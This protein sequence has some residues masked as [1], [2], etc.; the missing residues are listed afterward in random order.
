M[1]RGITSTLVVP[2]QI[3]LLALAL[4]ACGAT[5][6]QVDPGG[7]AGSGQRGSSEFLLPDGSAGVITVDG[8]SVGSDAV[9]GSAN[10]SMSQKPADVLLLLDRSGSMACSMTDPALDCKPT[11]GRTS[12]RWTVLSDGLR[13]VLDDSITGIHWGLKLFA[14]PS[15]DECGVTAGADVAVGAGRGPTIE[16]RMATTSQ[17]SATPTRAAIE[18]ATKYLLSLADGNPKYILLATDGQPNCTNPKRPSDNTS[19]LTAT[20]QAL[21]AAA[22]AGIKAF[23]I[24]VG[25]STGNLNQLADAG[26]TATFYPAASAEQLAEALQAIASQVISCTYSLGRVPPVLDKVGVYLD[27]VQVPASSTDGWS[28]GAGNDSITFNGSYCTGIKSGKYKSFDAMFGCKDTE[29]PSN[30]Q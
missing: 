9:C 26:G 7:T 24:G 5:P 25:P 16:Q 6:T 10:A 14:S 1:V 20:K 18:A 15:S 17:S 19:D 11:A 29:I 4:S 3:G 28:F 13:T 23:V 8:A 30:I 21:A 12:K 27:R 22:S 2:V